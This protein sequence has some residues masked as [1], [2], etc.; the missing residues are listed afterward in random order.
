MQRVNFRELGHHGAAVYVVECSD[1]IDGQHRVDW[2]TQK[3][4]KLLPPLLANW[5]ASVFATNRRNSYNGDSLDAFVPFWE[6]SQ[7]GQ[8]ETLAKFPQNCGSRDVFRCHVK[9]SSVS[10]SSKQTFRISYLQFLCP[11][12]ALSE[13][14]SQNF[15][16]PRTER[17]EERN[18]HLVKDGALLFLCSPSSQLTEGFV[19]WLCESSA[20]G[21]EKG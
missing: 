6:S 3:A 14:I 19:V 12:A 18:P 1:L 21:V 11:R 20:C 2:Q 9:S 5:R 10:V 7:K 4:R 13:S 17:P 15:S 16:N 8:H